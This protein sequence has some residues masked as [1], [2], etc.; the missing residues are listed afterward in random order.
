MMLPADRQI[1]ILWP[2]LR[3]TARTR[4][5]QPYSGLLAILLRSLTTLRLLDEEAGS[6]DA[7]RSGASFQEV[8]K[9]LHSVWLR[10]G[11][12]EISEIHAH[13]RAVMTEILHSDL[14]PDEQADLFTALDYLARL[15]AARS[16]AERVG[17][18]PKASLP[19][20]RHP[21][22][23]T[24]Y[25]LLAGFAATDLP[26]WLLGEHGTEQED[27]AR[28]V[29][30]LRGLPDAAFHVWEHGNP[31][32]AG[33]DR[34]GMAEASVFVPSVET[35]SPA[36]LRHL[37]DR[38]LEDFAK[39]GPIRY[40]IGTCPV[41]LEDGR[42]GDLLVEL[43][44]F[45]APTSVRVIPLRNRRDDLR[46]F[47]AFLSHQM[48]SPDP[49]PRIT[50]EA[51]DILQR[52]HWP[53]NTLEL[54]R[55]TAFLLRKRPTG[56]IRP[57]DLPETVKCGFHHPAG[58]SQALLAIG[59]KNRFRAL[60]SLEDCRALAAFLIERRT[61]RFSASDIQRLLSMGRETARRLLQA[62]EAGGLIEGIKGARACR[63]TGYRSTSMLND[64]A[65]SVKGSL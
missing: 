31:D 28:M 50:S 15:A 13:R 47:I 55:V 37:L 38:L 20:T 5:D 30:R 43:L 36:A 65:E 3:L 60:A 52:Y 16:I 23:Q 62:L 2:A 29:H 35:A 58:L 40:I 54:K 64:L 7:L 46:E 27:L 9:W 57:Q 44:V 21:D 33:T 51:M 63:M 19:P 8:T 4:Q 61:T 6:P 18:A 53:G 26:I 34:D 14:G 42:H 45:L 22:M 24:M 48:G 25:R 59:E 49:V 11:A 1:A 17:R 39:P 41:D 10:L 12:A 56:D 32:L